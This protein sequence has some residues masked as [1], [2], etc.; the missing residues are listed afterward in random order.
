M[1]P[2]FSMAPAAKSGIGNAEVVMKE[3]EQLLGHLEGKAPLLLLAWRGPDPDQRPLRLR[4]DRLELPHHERQQIGGHDGGFRETD[5]LPA[6]GV[7]GLAD[8]GHIGDGGEVG[9]DDH[10]EIEFGLIGWL[11]PAG[12]GASRIGRLEL[13]GGHHPLTPVRAGVLAAIQAAQLVVQLAGEAEGELRGARG[14]GRGK[15]ERDRLRAC[16][17][18]DLLSRDALPAMQQVGCLDIQ[19]GG[20]QHD[21]RCPLAH[22]EIDRLL[23]GKGKVGQM[24]RQRNPVSHGSDLDR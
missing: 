16:I 4:F 15:P 8:D 18:A 9:G 23:T 11:I 6:R 13:G 12:K 19:F 10:R 2:Q 22:L 17:A 20:I 14:Q 1:A 5:Q 24:W 21:L 7:G 3:G